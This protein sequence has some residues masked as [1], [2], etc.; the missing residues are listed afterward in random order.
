[1]ST[2]L[3]GMAIVMTVS[4]LHAEDN[5]NYADCDVCRGGIHYGP[6]EAKVILE[7]E[8]LDLF[9]LLEDAAKTIKL[10][11][12]GV[13]KTG[14]KDTPDSGY[15]IKIWGVSPFFIKDLRD[16]SMILITNSVNDPA[17]GPTMENWKPEIYLY[18]SK[19][20]EI[21]LKDSM[22]IAW[23]KIKSSGI[24]FWISSENEGNQ[25]NASFKKKILETLKLMTGKG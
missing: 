6:D 7:K 21:D 1:M 5:K 10:D 16:G 18:A 15:E 12:D 14:S 13:L 4:S 20:N 25:W 24:Y 2:F 8:C 9:V 22:D 3:I 11:L 19:S 23:E 17:R